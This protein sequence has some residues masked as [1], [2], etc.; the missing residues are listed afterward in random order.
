MM[1]QEKRQA[2]RDHNVIIKKAC[3]E[4]THVH[5]TVIVDDLRQL[6]DMLAQMQARGEPNSDRKKIKT[7]T[8]NHLTE[9]TRMLS[10]ALKERNECYNYR[11]IRSKLRTFCAQR[12]KYYQEQKAI[13][14]DDHPIEADDPSSY[15]PFHVLNFLD[16]PVDNDNFDM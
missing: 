5:R 1:L 15:K 3:S 2:F 8:L 4:G 10:T 12:E 6:V 7:T 13:K 16:V 11:M 9:L 14:D